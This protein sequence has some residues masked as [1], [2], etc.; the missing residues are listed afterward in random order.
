VSIEQFIGVATFAI[1]L[2]QAFATVI[3]YKIRLD[4][5]EEFTALRERMA[6]FE[7]ALGYF[8]EGF[9]RGGRRTQA[10]E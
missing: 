1:L 6:R 9:T 10:G 3:S 2:G 5:A 7:T 8:P 4:V